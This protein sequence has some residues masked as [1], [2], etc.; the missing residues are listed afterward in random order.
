MKNDCI[1]VAQ[2][3]EN[4]HKRNQVYSKLFAD[5]IMHWCLRPPFYQCQTLNPL[6]VWGWGVWFERGVV[7]A[8]KL[9]Q[10]DKV[11]LL[12]SVSIPMD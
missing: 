12:I 6:S 2:S 5:D 4:K 11:R 3:L 1:C 7:I 8:R 9:K 10:N